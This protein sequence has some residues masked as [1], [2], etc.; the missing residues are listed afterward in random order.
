MS[1]QEAGWQGYVIYKGVPAAS[2]LVGGSNA[3]PP[4]PA[5]LCFFSCFFCTCVWKEGV[6]I[7]QTY[8][9]GNFLALWHYTTCEVI[10]S[11]HANYEPWES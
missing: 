9:V 10:G 3:T 1:S 8:M 6:M 11:D 5:Q 2:L 7:L 4:A